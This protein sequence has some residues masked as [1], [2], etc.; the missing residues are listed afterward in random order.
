MAENEAT[1][2]VTVPHGEKA[3]GP[4]E[5]HESPVISESAQAAVTGAVLAGTAAAEATHQAE[6]AREAVSEAEARAAQLQTELESN[7]ATH[8]EHRSRLTSLET[9]RAEIERKIAEAEEE[10][11]EEAGE[12][13]VPEAPVAPEAEVNAPPQA[14]RSWIHKA[15][16]GK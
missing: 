4:S 1:V 12:I 5:S 11:E 16:L 13:E 2:E 8:E 9:W 15:L 14:K 3:D 10:P 7:R 6:E